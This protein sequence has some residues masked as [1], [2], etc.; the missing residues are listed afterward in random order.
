LL[1][2][3]I[4]QNLNINQIISCCYYY[5]YYQGVYNPNTYNNR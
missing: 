5:Y 4:F 2:V 1:A 3:S